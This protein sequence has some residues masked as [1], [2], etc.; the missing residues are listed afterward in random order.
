[1]ETPFEKLFHQACHDNLIQQEA[2]T[3]TQKHTFNASPRLGLQDPTSRE[4]TVFVTRT[5]GQNRVILLTSSLQMKISINFFLKTPPLLPSSKMY[6]C[7]IDPRI[8]AAP[9]R[10]K[11]AFFSPGRY[12]GGR[13]LIL[14]MTWAALSALLGPIISHSSKLAW[15]QN[16]HQYIGI[17]SVTIFSMVP[18]S[19]DC[20]YMHIYMQCI[21]CTIRW[22]VKMFSFLPSESSQSPLPGSERNKRPSVEQS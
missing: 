5:F 18:W 22:P 3:R 4:F 9:E 15:F 1:M 20:R 13:T 17:A 12:E 21:L 11:S 8:W 7:Y 2:T 14:E 19:S 10:I 6:S 16:C